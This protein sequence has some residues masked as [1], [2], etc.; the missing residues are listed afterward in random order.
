MVSR[1]RRTVLNFFEPA[2]ESAP[3]GLLDG[4]VVF[5]FSESDDSKAVAHLLN[6]EKR[7]IW[8]YN[9]LD[10]KRR[11]SGVNFGQ[12]VQAAG[13]FFFVSGGDTLAAG[14]VLAMAAPEGRDENLSV[15]EL[16][17]PNNSPRRLARTLSI[18]EATEASVGSP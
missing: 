15:E 2:D 12:A 9:F 10:R 3:R 1:P 13:G 6:E 11:H 18:T 17:H 8:R 7:L 5:V 16:I 4:I 14:G